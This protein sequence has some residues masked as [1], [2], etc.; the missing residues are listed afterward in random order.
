M[1][2][3][4]ALEPIILNLSMEATECYMGFGEIR[5]FKVT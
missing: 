1:G 3:V 4:W 5:F 2:N